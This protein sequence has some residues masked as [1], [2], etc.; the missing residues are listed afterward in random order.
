MFNKSFEFVFIFN[1]RMGSPLGI[2]LEQL[3]YVTQFHS[4]CLN[5]YSTEGKYLNSVGKSGEEHL[6]FDHPLGLVV[7]REKDRIYIADHRNNRVLL[8]EISTTMRF[9]LL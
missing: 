4:N 2:C 1:E 5:L 8:Y 3:L 9:L 7:S 6:E